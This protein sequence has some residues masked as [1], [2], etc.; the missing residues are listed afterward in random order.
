MKGISLS[1]YV[2]PGKMALMVG[3]EGTGLAGERRGECETLL[4]I[5]MPGGVDSLNVGVAA[6]IFLYA[7]GQN[8]A[9]QSPAGLP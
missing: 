9:Q 4:T 2:P 5:P 8:P 1:R 3:N 6:G 7:L